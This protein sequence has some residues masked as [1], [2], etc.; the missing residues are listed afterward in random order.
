[1]RIRF[2]LGILTVLC[3]LTLG[4]SIASASYTYV[5][6][7]EVDQGPSWGSQPAA[8]SGQQAAALLFG[9]NASD[10]AISTVGSSPSTINHEAW[11]SVL[12]YNGPNNGGIA[13]ADSYLSSNSSQNPGYYFSGNNAYRMGDSTEAASAYVSDNADSG[14][15]NYAFTG[16]AVP[17]P[18][19][20]LLL[21]PG[22]AGF[23]A[24]RRKFK[25]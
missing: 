12:G 13:F 9:G 20:V 10:Y 5:G 25:G 21:A 1:M 24:M 14:N 11:Y 7:W 22:L 17:L 2:Y 4:P 23:F 6:S 3:L 15:I 19:S 8:Y 18:P 16:S